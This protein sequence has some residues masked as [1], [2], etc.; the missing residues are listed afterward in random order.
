MEMEAGVELLT[1]SSSNLPQPNSSSLVI[2]QNRPT[3][4]AIGLTGFAW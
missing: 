4:D 3:D 1:H 2:E